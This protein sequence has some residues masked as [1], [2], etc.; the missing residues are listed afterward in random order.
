MLLENKSGVGVAQEYVIKEL[1]KQY[2][3]PQIMLPGDDR[4]AAFNAKQKYNGWLKK[5][6]INTKESL[7]VRWNSILPVECY[8]GFHSVYLMNTSMYRSIHPCVKIVWI[9]DMMTKIYPQ[10]YSRKDMEFHQVLFSNIKYADL[11]ITVSETTKQDVVR[12]CNISPNKI[13]VIY[14]GID[15]CYRNDT[16]SEHKGERIDYTKKYVFYIGDMRK[17]KNLL[18]AVKGYERYLTSSG[19][20]CYFYIAG[21]K[22]Y[23]YAHI[24]RYVKEKHLDEKVL[25]LGYVTDE[26]KMQLY[27]RAFALL[28]VSLYE[29]FGIPIIEAMASRTPVI[30][31]NASSMKELAEGYGV[32]VNPC[33]IEEIGHAIETLNDRGYREEIINRAYKYSKKFNWKQT[34]SEFGKAITEAYRAKFKISRFKIY[35][36]SVQTDIQ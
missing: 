16:K 25:F 26:E 21:N 20:E 28:F 15:E 29:G 8:Y 12:F 9:H 3:L 36:H 2:Y 30:T 23:E 7:P 14:L 34:G 4:D 13:K 5:Y 35:K 24:L 10:N 17:N 6:I 33:E 31:S 18:N 22:R 1:I 11:V 19:D 32:L 27:R